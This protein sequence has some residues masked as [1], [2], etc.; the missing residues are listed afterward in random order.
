MLESLTGDI[1]TEVVIILLIFCILY[2]CIQFK[3]KVALRLGGGGYTESENIT[4]SRE[5]LLATPEISC[6]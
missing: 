1:S 6:Y 3:Y 2:T 4:G 5:H